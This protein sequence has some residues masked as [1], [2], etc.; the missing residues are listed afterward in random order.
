MNSFGY[1]YSTEHEAACVCIHLYMYLSVS[2]SLYLSL[3]LSI[4]IYIYIYI[5]IW[6]GR[7]AACGRKLPLFFALDF[8]THLDIMLTFI[9][10]RGI[11]SLKSVCHLRVIGNPRLKRG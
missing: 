9:I 11:G 6:V 4:Y 2:L 3:S 7:Y 5:Y 10:R 1:D 8:E